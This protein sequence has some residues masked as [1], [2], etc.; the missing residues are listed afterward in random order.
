MKTDNQSVLTRK[1]DEITLATDRPQQ[2]REGIKQMHEATRNA[3]RAR[4][5]TNKIKLT[6]AN[7]PK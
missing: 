7:N 3:E 1:I 4:E 2:T 6:S 5:S